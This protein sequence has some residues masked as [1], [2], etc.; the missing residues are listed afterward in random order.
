MT[1]SKIIA[2]LVTAILIVLIVW[3][4]YWV[5]LVYVN[6][7]DGQNE[8]DASSVPAE[9]AMAGEGSEEDHGTAYSQSEKLQI[10]LDRAAGQTEAQVVDDADTGTNTTELVATEEL[11]SNQKLLIIQ[12]RQAEDPNQVAEE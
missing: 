4:L 10:I 12:R 5:Y 7:V 9:P 8:S 2:I 1:S 6:P 11:D 3:A